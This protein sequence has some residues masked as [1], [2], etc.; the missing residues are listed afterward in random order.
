MMLHYIDNSWG[1]G[2]AEVS[3]F[4]AGGDIIMAASM[5]Q[6]NSFGFTIFALK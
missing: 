1:V 2:R 3:L 6:D 4:W 5:F